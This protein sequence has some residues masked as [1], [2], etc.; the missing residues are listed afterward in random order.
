MVFFLDRPP[1]TFGCIQRAFK[2]H[3]TV[4]DAATIGAVATW[5]TTLFHVA[6]GLWIADV[7][8]NETPNGHW[9]T[10]TLRCTIDSERAAY[11]FRPA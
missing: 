1:R 2:P 7:A 9:V 6:Y 8:E 10:Y 3:A 4:G 5:A 11:F